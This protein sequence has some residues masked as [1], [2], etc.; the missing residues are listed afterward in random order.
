MEQEGEK[1]AYSVATPA[2]GN[3]RTLLPAIAIGK[4]EIS[5]IAIGRHRDEARALVRFV[6][7]AGRLA[8]HAESRTVRVTFRQQKVVDYCM[9]EG[10]GGNIALVHRLRTISALLSGK[11]GD[12]VR[13]VDTVVKMVWLITTHT[14]GLYLFVGLFGSFMLSS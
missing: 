6:N 9:S 1:V 11:T 13:E 12:D 7:G 14:I 10:E 5:C 3:N 8:R 2:G 4:Q